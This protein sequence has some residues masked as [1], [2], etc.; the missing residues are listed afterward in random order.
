MKKFLIFLLPL[1]F[2]SCSQMDNSSTVGLVLSGKSLRAASDIELEYNTITVSASLKG[3]VSRQIQKKVSDFSKDTVIVFDSVPAG[4]NIYVYVSI[5]QVLEY[6][7]NG[8]PAYSE[9]LYYGKSPAFTVKSGGNTVSVNL[10]SSQSSAFYGS[11]DENASGSGENADS[12]M[13]INAIFDEINESNIRYASIYINSSDIELDA[14]K[15]LPEKT[16]NFTNGESDFLCYVYLTEESVP[17]VQMYQ[18]L[19]SVSLKNSKGTPC[20][21]NLYPE[22]VTEFDLSLKNNVCAV[23]ENSPSLTVNFDGE[24]NSYYENEPFLKAMAK[25]T[26]NDCKISVVL[27][28]NLKQKAEVVQ[29][30]DTDSSYYTFKLK[31][32]SSG[33]NTGENPGNQPSMDID[34]SKPVLLFN[35]LETYKFEVSYAV[36]RDIYSSSD[37]I[38]GSNIFNSSTMAANGFFEDIAVDSSGNVYSLFSFSSSSTSAYSVIYSEWGEDSY[39]SSVKY[40]ISNSPQ[41]IY[42]I[43]K[44]SDGNIYILYH[45]DNIGIG[46]LTLGGTSATY[47]KVFDFSSTGL[48]SCQTFTVDENGNFYVIYVIYLGSDF[49]TYIAQFDSS[50]NIISKAQ[51]DSALSFNDIFYSSGVLYASAQGADFSGGSMFRITTSGNEFSVQKDN[52]DVYN[53][54][55]IVSIIPGYLVIADSGK[56]SGG[57]SQ[58]RLCLY[59]ESTGTVDKT[60][61]TAVSF[62]NIQ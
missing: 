52:A 26:G 38:S 39:K 15:I 44:G 28:D 30:L 55:K 35:G 22:S 36:L 54:V 58:S 25:N 45:Q 4:K 56:D 37:S 61:D 57:N 34:M 60:F 8:E 62:I 7:E 5:D 19:S 3:D 41:S 42:Q 10:K 23:I 29:N 43:E 32:V 12:P 17:Y 13:N 47:E 59:N 18:A 53:P 6:N 16:Y 49:S 46:K 50:G 20:N 2:I 48:S 31:T 9:P 33:G 51:I 40:D 27:G 14:A 1:L 21:F 11:F 24:Y